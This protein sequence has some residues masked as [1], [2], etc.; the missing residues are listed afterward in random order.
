[1]HRIGLSTLLV[2][3]LA[4]AQGLGWAQDKI[5]NLKPLGQD[6]PVRVVTTTNFITDLAQQVGGERVQVTGLMGPGVDPHLYKASAGDVRRLA[7]ADV[8]FYGGLDLEGKMVELLERNPKAIA[9]TL[10][11]PKERLLKPSATLPSSMR[12]D[13]H[14]WFDV[15]LW[16]FTVNVVRDALSKLDPAGASAYADNAA[17]Y[18][19][20]LDQLDAFAERE[21]SRVPPA[22]RV[23][24]TAHDA[25]SYFGKR[26][27]VEVRGLQGVST[28]AEA[29]TKDIQDLADFIVRRKIPAIFVESSVPQRTIEAVA[30]A[31]KARGFSVK[32][33]GSLFSDSAG[34]PGTPQGT[35]VGMVEHNV[36]TIVAALLGNMP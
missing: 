16:K 13:P 28:V 1:M 3:G 4:F 17:R 18:L 29:G 12:V 10:R 22:Q 27:K 36:R 15:S 2:F 32:I 14:V 24:I 11:I 19:K 9:V 31:V 6:R 30:A 20:R 21:L 33:G 34:S 5:E 7:R 26:Y 25:F 8:V 35:Y 23:L